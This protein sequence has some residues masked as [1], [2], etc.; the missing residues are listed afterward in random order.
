LFTWAAGEKKSFR[1]QY[2]QGPP[3]TVGREL[4]FRQTSNVGRCSR[5]SFTVV[6]DNYFSTSP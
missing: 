3:V 4:S 2:F 6:P 1:A 5:G